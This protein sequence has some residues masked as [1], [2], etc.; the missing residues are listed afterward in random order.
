MTTTI[1]STE[2][3][4][5]AL[6]E[7]LRSNTLVLGELAMRYGI[8]TRPE[9]GGHLPVIT[10]SDAAW[11]L[12]GTEMAALVQEQLRVLLLDAQ[13]RVIAQRVIYQGNITSVAVRPAEVVR[14]AVVEAVSKMILVHNHPSG[15]P[16]PSAAD[17]A[18]TRAIEQAA[19]LLAIEVLDH[20]VIG[21]G[22]YVSFKDR[23]LLSSK[24]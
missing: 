24:P 14:P 17:I 8:E 15:D 18:I 10:T 23:G 21:N 12:L 6:L 2:S 3:T 1:M 11:M 9:R 13:Q 5:Q 16:E 22:R 4:P 19:N 20:L 7:A